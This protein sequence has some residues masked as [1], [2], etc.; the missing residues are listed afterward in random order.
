VKI[1]EKGACH[2]T[3]QQQ[4]KRYRADFIPPSTT[5][6]SSMSSSSSLSPDSSP[7]RRWYGASDFS[8]YQRNHNPRTH[9]Q[10]PAR[11][12]VTTASK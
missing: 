7:R 4:R 1:V 12:A 10:C 2:E 9:H 5:M 3:A 8:R 11:K 6:T